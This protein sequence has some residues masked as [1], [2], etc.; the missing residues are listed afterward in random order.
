MAVDLAFVVDTGCTLA[1]LAELVVVAAFAALVELAVVEAFVAWA[2]LF[3]ESAA[4]VAV[5]AAAV[6]VGVFVF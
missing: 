2:E 4:V 5:V 3:V 6:V 1:G